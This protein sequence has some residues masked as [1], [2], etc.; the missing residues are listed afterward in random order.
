MA[1][2]T[3]L[4]VIKSNAANG[5]G[6]GMIDEVSRR[7]PFMSRGAFRSIKGVNYKTL[8]QTGASNTAGSF[9]K[10]NSGV[11]PAT[12]T[13]ENRLV[14]T[15]P[16]QPRFHV[17]AQ[18]ADNSEDGSA[19]FM[20][21]KVKGILETEFIA[22][23]KQ[24]FYGAASGLGNAL[25]YPGLLDAYDATNMVTDAGGTTANT[26]SSVWLVQFGPDSV[27]GVLANGGEFVFG[28]VRLESLVDPNNAGTYIDMYVQTLRAQVGLQV[29][30]VL[31][32]ARIKKLTADAGHTLTDKLLMDTIA[33]FPQMGPNAIFMSLRSL[34]QLR[35]SRTATNPTGQE[36]PFPTSITGIDGGN[37][38]IYPTA[39]LLNTEAL[40]L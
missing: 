4:D 27:T 7:T 6:I 38:P 5:N 8:V 3:L 34:A 10:L 20:S 32:I 40:T 35:D 11:A 30:N 17:D 26:G 1:Y 18:V 39:G 21:R 19:A 9:R 14:E 16:I 24:M 25:G 31:R 23:E 15:Y 37:I 36:A 12:S 13:E 28:T 29:A 22:H 2:T 33:L